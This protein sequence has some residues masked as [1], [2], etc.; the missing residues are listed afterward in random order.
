MMLWP[1][2]LHTWTEVSAAPDDTGTAARG[3]GTGP[4]WQEGWRDEPSACP[5]PW[6]SVAGGWAPCPAAAAAADCTSSSPPCPWT[7]RGGVLALA[8]VDLCGP[9]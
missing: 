8:G 3:T 5:G 9:C 7:C 6:G 2:C 4:V 1:V